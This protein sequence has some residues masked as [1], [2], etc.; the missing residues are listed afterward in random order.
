MARNNN[1]RRLLAEMN[2]VP[3]IDVMLVLVVILMVAAPYVNPSMVDLPSVHSASR[4][5]DKVVEVIVDPN[6]HLSV[7]SDGNLTPTD[8]PKLIATIESLNKDGK[9]VPVVIA[10]D[11]TVSYEKVVNVMKQ[12]QLANISRIGLS[13]K[14]EGSR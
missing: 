5:P 14:I 13:L 8:L 9:Q 4:T 2:V 3:Y 1:R 10:A 6:G 11:K 7:R 12:L